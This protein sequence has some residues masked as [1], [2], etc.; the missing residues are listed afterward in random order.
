[1]DFVLCKN[2]LTFDCWSVFP[3]YLSHLM[4]HNMQNRLLAMNYIEEGHDDTLF[5]VHRLQLS[6]M[7]FF[8]K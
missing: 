5:E 2:S 6:L 4:H 7:N 3:L 8:Y 1:M